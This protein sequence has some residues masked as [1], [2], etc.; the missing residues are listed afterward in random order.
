M[1]L[2]WTPKV[3]SANIFSVIWNIYL[4]F[5]THKSI[6]VEASPTKG[7][8]SKKAGNKKKGK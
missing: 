2:P 8:H 1:A 3:L 5:T 6:V 4:S 7:D